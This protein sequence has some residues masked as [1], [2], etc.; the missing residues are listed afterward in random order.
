MIINEGDYMSKLVR[1]DPFADLDALQRQL[2]D[3]GDTD[4]MRTVHMPTT[5]IYTNDDKE[6]VVEA[7]LPN[8]KDEDV[9]VSVDDNYLVIQAEKY[10]KEE[11]KKKKKYVVRESSSSLYRRIYLPERANGDAIQAHFDNGLLKVT[12]PFKELPKPKKIMIASKSGG[13]AK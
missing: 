6:M 13:K 9:N 1:F 11:D 4:P 8:F 3:I 7:H 2:F 10:E 5:D 12:V